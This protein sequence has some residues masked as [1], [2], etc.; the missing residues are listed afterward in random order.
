M[1]TILIIFC[2][3]LLFSCKEKENPQIIYSSITDVGAISGRITASIGDTAIAGAMITTNPSTHKVYSDSSG[4]YTLPD[5]PP[6]DYTIV[7]SKTGFFPDSTTVSLIDWRTVEVDLTLSMLQV[8]PGFSFT[9]KWTGTIGLSAFVKSLQMDLNQ[10]GIDSI[11]GDMIFPDAGIPGYMADPNPHINIIQSA[12]RVANDSFYFS[13]YTKNLLTGAKR[14]GEVSGKM[15]EYR[16]LTGKYHSVGPTGVPFDLI[17][18]V[19]RVK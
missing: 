19:E 17:F 2:C 3:F 18:W 16:Y 14:P 9:G 12:L 4:N 6:G 15:L 11:T 13:T 10:I 1:K 8:I 5:M 7:V